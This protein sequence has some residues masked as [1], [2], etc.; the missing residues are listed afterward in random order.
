MR[1]LVPPAEALLATKEGFG[2]DMVRR[3][4]VDTRLADEEYGPG[5]LDEE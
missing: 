5:W 1:K 2:A 4:G 3:L